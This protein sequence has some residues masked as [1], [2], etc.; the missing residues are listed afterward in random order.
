MSSVIEEVNAPGD[1]WSI[2][3]A[4]IITTAN[5]Q[6]SDKCHTHLRETF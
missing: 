3:T 1:Q 6:A 2:R 5:Y 4:C